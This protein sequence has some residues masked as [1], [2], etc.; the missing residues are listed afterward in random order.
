MYSNICDYSV[1]KL[2]K[3]LCSHALLFPIIFCSKYMT[4]FTAS[5]VLCACKACSELRSSHNPVLPLSLSLPPTASSDKGMSRIL[6]Q[7]EIR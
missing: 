4:Y 5:S 6:G 1:V 3:I 2:L 7:S